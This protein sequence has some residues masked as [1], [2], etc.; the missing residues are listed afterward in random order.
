[1]FNNRLLMLVSIAIFFL[2]IIPSAFGADNQTDSLKADLDAQ[3]L[4][5][6][7][8]FD[9]NATNDHGEGTA[10]DPYRELRDG[11]ILDNSVIHLKN[12]QYDY[13]QLNTHAN[14]S[15]IGQDASKTIINGNGGTLLFNDRLS[16]TNVTI[17]NLNIL[18][19]GDLTAANTVFTHSSA[20][21]IGRGLGGAIYCVND[22][23][24]AY[25]T[26]CTFIDNYAKCGGAIYLSGGNLEITDCAFINNTALNYGGA[27]ACE[28]KYSRN[29]KITIKRCE[30][31]NDVSLDDAGGAVYIKSTTFIGEDLNVSSCRGTFGGAFALL[32]SNNELNNVYAFNNIALYDGGFIYQIYGNLTIS[33]SRLL[34]NHARNGGGL[35]VD[36][37]SS[38]D[39]SNIIFVDNSADMAAGAF[40][41]LVNSHSSF[42]NLTFI[43]NTAFEYNDLFHQENIS[44]IFSQGNYTLYHHTVDDSSLPRY[45]SSVDEGYVTPVKNQQNGGNCW[46]FAV[47]AALE[48]A[49]LKASGDNL[50]LSEENMKNLAAAYSH[51]GWAMDTNGG[52][53]DDM[54]FGYLTSWLGPVL[55]MDDVYDDFSVLSPVLNSILHVQNVVFLKKSTYYNLDSIKKAI[56]DY[57]AVYTP[58]FID[59]HYDYQTGSYVQCYRGDLA[60]NH[61]V[62]LVGWDDDF[63]ISGAP[64]KGAWIAKNSWGDDWGNNGYFYVSYFDNSCPKLGDNEGAYA[65]IFNDT[66]KYDKNYQY[67]IAKTDY[68]FNTTKTVWYKNVFTVTDSEYLAAVST[69]FEKDTHWDLTVR[70]N[71]IVKTEK[72]GDCPAGYYTIELPEFIPVDVGDVFEIMFKITVDGDA[73]VPISEKISLNN[74]FYHENISYISYDGNNWKDLFN[75]TWEYP[76][77][78]YKSQVACIKAFTISNPINTTVAL[79]FENRT[80]DKI[81]VVAEVLNQWGYHVTSGNLVLVI[82]DKAYVLNMTDGVAKIE[83]SLKSAN[84]TA[85]FS[86]VG[87]A[88]CEKR[89]ELHN[90]LVKTNITLNVSGQYNP[91][92]ITATVVDE[93]NN[94]VRYGTVVFDIE[95]KIYMADVANGTA[96]LENIVLSS[97]KGIINAQFSDLFYY[98]SSNTKKS[99]ELSLINTK[100]Y[101]NITTNEFKNP[102]T[103]VAHVLDL[104]GNPVK[105]GR[106]SF[107]MSDELY[108]L[109]VVGGIAAINHTFKHTGENTIDATYYGDYLYNSSVCSEMLFVSKMK[110][111]LTFDIVVDECDAYMAI[112]IRNASRGFTIYLKVNDTNYTYS[113]DG[114]Y[115]VSE[116]KNLKKGS[117]N[118]AIRVNSSVYEADDLEGEFNITYQRTDIVAS[119][120]EVYYNGDYR[121]VL[122]DELGNIIGNRDVYL[123]IDDQTIK[124]RTDDDGIAVFKT[125]LPLGTYIAKVSF[126]GDDEYVKSSK[127]IM[128]NYISTIEFSSSVYTLNAGYSATLRDSNGN[129]LKNSLVKMVLNGVSYDLISDGNGK[130][131]FKINLNPGTYGVKITNEVSGEVK[132]QTIS[133]VK[134]IT[135]NKAVTM[136]YGAGKYYKVKVFDDYGNA[137]KGVKVTFTINNKKYTRTTNNNGYA[138]FK[139]SLKP[140]KYTITAEYKGFKVS[141]RITVKSTIITKNIAVKKGKT[142]KFTAKLLNKNGKILKNKKVTFK[143]RGKTY[144][145]KTKRKGIAVLKITKKYKKG[146]YAI[147]SQ[148][149]TLKVKNK[150]RIK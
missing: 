58:I 102:V 28:S 18:N 64:G 56:R 63:Y 100:V 1:M 121:I 110:V 106:I 125:S 128:I 112:G 41:S 113:S 2:L 134:R 118:Y 30:F 105:S 37:S 120:A 129:L 38:L 108:V 44:I 140:A 89:I 26:N 51:Y 39:A 52:G 136:Y 103:V 124:K 22:N 17:C 19:Q 67:D 16:L 91:I 111:N 85:E 54:G 132:T 141:N 47:L 29:S 43:N 145:I 42:T 10:D 72:S 130:I 15:F 8:Y 12:G 40:Y 68:F 92:N 35:F 83:I 116:L 109:D 148:Y 14:V 93:H 25:L 11:R 27:I 5:H 96:K 6:D 87:Y 74:C 138:S 13:F 117:Y 150:I 115:V 53:Y 46:A 88:S 34:K 127:T 20:T 65:F 76:D 80:S 78:T 146:T 60:C 79:T 122:K 137:A 142:I 9:S 147:S 66:I 4:V 70:V 149:G 81:T 77:H 84:I 59:A 126:I 3:T 71:D 69:Y 55:E 57:G 99:V 82:D 21:S 48:S 7:F 107:H 36:N 104:N 73:G 133:V 123:T 31:I 135:E 95:G 49:I 62:V 33:D 144:K 23:N 114:S 45:Y 98:N 86:G 119:D 90:P 139:I 61:A 101:L 75:L 24:N 131:S 32:Q 50:D 143:F 94:M 97:L